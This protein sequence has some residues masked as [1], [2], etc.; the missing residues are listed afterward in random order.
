SVG[1]QEDEPTCSPTSS[2]APGLR[3][4]LLGNAAGNLRVAVELHGVHRTTLG[5]GPQ[6]ADV[7][8]HLR[9][10]DESTDVLDPAHV[11]H[12]LHLTAS[13]FPVDD[14]I[15]HLLLQSMDRDAHDR[16]EDDGLRLTQSFLDRKEAGDL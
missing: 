13:G 4:D 3:D 8:E 7:A 14:Y 16:L 1:D 12:R 2:L 15:S 6:I 5:L 9:Q 10:R 11:L